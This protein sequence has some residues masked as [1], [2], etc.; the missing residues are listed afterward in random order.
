MP[1]HFATHLETKH[2]LFLRLK[3]RKEI[4]RAVRTIKGLAEREDEVVYPTARLEPVPH[5]P[6]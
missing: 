3:T 4:A 6:V 1:S 5:L 2:A